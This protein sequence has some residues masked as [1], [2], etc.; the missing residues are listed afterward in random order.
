[1]FKT[2]LVLGHV[3]GIR[4]Q[5]HISWIFILILL[6]ASMSTGFYHQYPEWSLAM[7]V[8]TAAVTALLFFSSILA[9]ELGHSMVALRR[10][11]PV[12][13]I[14]L[15]IFGGLAQMGRDPERAEDEF[16][17][18]IAGPAVSAAL[19]LLFWWLALLTADWFEPVPVALGWLALINMIVAI[20]NLIPGFPL[21]GGRVFRAV[22]WKLTGDPRRAIEAAV[23]GGRMVA[24]LLFGFAFWN[25]VVLG[26]LIGGLWVML[27]AWFL[28]NMAEMQGRMY[29]MRERLVDVRARDLANPDPPF[30][31][32]DVSVEEW[33]D[34]FVLPGGRRSF[35][36]GDA[37]RVQGLVTLSD[38]RKVPRERW[39]TTRIAAIMTPVDA[40]SRVAPDTKAEEILQVM[41]EHNLNQI[42]VMDESGRAIG[43]IDRQQLLRTIE[44]HMELQ[45]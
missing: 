29:D 8:G 39:P 1:M 3:S 12:E 23:R 31:G 11:V 15:F 7:A 26:N 37:E 45:R 14:T 13:S 17:I 6:L 22:I 35:L 20:F 2:V 16:W 34:R 18:A 36:V 32:Q 44:I 33:I 21:D 9:H 40:L 42:P 5:I 43:W 10:G 38:S 24:Y 25:V 30:V 28:L 27:I 41:S 19:A 4:I